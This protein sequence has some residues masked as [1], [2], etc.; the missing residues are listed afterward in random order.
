[1]PTQTFHRLPEERRARLVE[2]AIEAFSER[3]YVEA[4]LSKIAERARIPKGSFYQYFTDKLDLYRWLIADETPR[5]KRAFVGP[6]TGEHDFFETLERFV[7]R[8]MAFLVEHPRLAQLTARAADPSALPEVRGLH[9][10]VCDASLGELREL[11]E[12]GVREGAI[13]KNGELDVHVRFVA[14]IIG[15]GLVDAILYELD[16]ELYEVL[17]S[18]ALRA[19]LDARMRQRLAH[20]A[21]EMIRAGIG[22]RPDTRRQR[23]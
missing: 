15:P 11:L 20:A 9:K 6:V 16:A 5:L 7:E 13:A 14:A 10:R 22:E 3:P 17:L 12:R 8:G 18:D 1:M 2:A 4:S 23:R 19:R 21:V